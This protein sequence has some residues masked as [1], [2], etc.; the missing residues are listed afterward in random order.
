MGEKTVWNLISWFHRELHCSSI[1]KKFMFVRFILDL[2][3]N[4][5]SVMS[6]R[7]FLG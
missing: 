7:V 5:F 4:N 6:G 2:S 3:V 1:L